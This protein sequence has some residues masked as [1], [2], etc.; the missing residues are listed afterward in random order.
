VGVGNFG[1]V[2]FGV[3]YFT[4]DS[5]TLGPGPKPLD[6]NISLKFL[7]WKLG[8]NLSLLMLWMTC[9]ISGSKIIDYLISGLINI[10]F[11]L[12]HNF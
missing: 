8:K 2:R 10:L 3:G 1:K 12:G 4:S 9:W 11:I 7:N 5:A 6:G